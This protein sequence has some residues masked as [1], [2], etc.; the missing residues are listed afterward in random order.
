LTGD[1]EPVAPEVRQPAVEREIILT[2]GEREFVRRREDEQPTRLK[3]AINIFGG[4][5]P[6]LNM[7]EDI[8]R[9]DNV[10]NLVAY[11]RVF[12]VT[13]INVGLDPSYSAADLRDYEKKSKVIASA[14]RAGRVGAYFGSSAS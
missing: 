9:H 3:G 10:V 11:V 13:Q 7:L 4:A 2:G 5:L 8:I 12:H 1:T 14:I 6:V